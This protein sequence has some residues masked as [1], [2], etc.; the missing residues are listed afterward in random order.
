VYMT[1]SELT[2]MAPIACGQYYWVYRL[3]PKDYRKF[4]SY[5]IAWLTA[6]AWIATVAIESLL[7][8]TIVQGLIKLSHPT[9]D[10][11]PF[12]GTFLTWAVIVVNII[13]NVA[14][15]DSLPTLELMILAL[16]LVGFVAIMVTLLSTAKIGSA[17]SV[18][19]TAF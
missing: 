15:P 7:A 1:I 11:Q 3:A 18:W 4:S 14:T 19:L 8:G 6:L 16:H 10:S 13:I 17:S 9:Y 5:I 12:H 2:S